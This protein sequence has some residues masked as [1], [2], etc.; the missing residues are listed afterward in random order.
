[1]VAF[2]GLSWCQPCRF[3][4]PNV[5]TCRP[6]TQGLSQANLPPEIVKYFFNLTL[7]SQSA[8]LNISPLRKGKTGESRCSSVWESK[9]IRKDGEENQASEKAKLVKTN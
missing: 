3:E 7:I 4:A 9:T 6:H 2:E 8:I 5:V 1:V